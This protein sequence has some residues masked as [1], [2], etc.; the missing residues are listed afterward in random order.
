[1]QEFVNGTDAQYAQLKA[2]LE[3]HMCHVYRNCNL[4]QGC[5]PATARL[6]FEK[7]GN[8]YALFIDRNVTCSKRNAP[9][10]FQQ[11]LSSGTLR[12]LDYSD[13][14]EF[15]RSLNCLY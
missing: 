8:T 9:E 12:F 6:G 14:K 15:L 4:P 5:S 2:S 1:M 11:W 13:M 7:E 3:D 10:L